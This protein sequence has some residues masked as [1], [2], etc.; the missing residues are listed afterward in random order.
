MSSVTQSYCY[1]FFY[2]LLL[3]TVAQSTILFQSWDSQ[4]VP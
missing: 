4:N 2:V 3:D 1:G